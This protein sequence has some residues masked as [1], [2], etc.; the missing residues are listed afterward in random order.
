MSDQGLDLVLHNQTQSKLFI[1]ARTYQQ[2]KQNYLEIMF[3]GEELGKRY[4]LESD[5]QEL[6]MIEEPVYVRDREGR[7][8]TYTDQRVPVSKALPGYTVHV[9]RVTLDADG[10]EISREQVSENT[11]EAAPPMIYVGMQEREE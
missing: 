8:A 7:Y 1:S 11:Y 3:I 2:D 10:Q 4:A 9:A 6:P 5:V